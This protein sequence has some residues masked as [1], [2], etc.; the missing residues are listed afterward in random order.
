MVRY[1]VY[2]NRFPSRMV[3]YKM[4]HREDCRYAKEPDDNNWHGYFDDL[5]HAESFAV[6]VHAESEDIR[7]CKYCNP[8]ES[9]NFF[10]N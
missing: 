8:R 4:I 9:D 3:Y 2:F 5:N 1:V 10:S 6:R 7:F